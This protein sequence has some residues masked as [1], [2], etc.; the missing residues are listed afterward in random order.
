MARVI[1]RTQRP[2]SRAELRQLAG[3]RE[4]RGRPR[5]AAAGAVRI[6]EGAI[7]SFW[8]K[9][10]R[11]FTVCTLLIFGYASIDPWS[12]VLAKQLRERAAVA[13]VGSTTSAARFDSTLR[14]V[15]SSVEELSN[16]AKSGQLGAPLARLEEGL[17]QLRDLREEVLADFAET[18]EWLGEKG[19]PEQIR[20]RHQSAVDAFEDSYR[21]LERQ[22][23]KTL[24]ASR[25]A[26]R[27]RGRGPATKEIGILEKSLRDAEKSLDRLAPERPHTPI[28]P[29][30]L[31]HRTAELK[32]QAPR[33]T[34]AE[35]D[36]AA[37]AVDATTPGTKAAPATPDDVAPTVDAQFTPEII[38]LAASLD[39]DP[40]KIYEFVRNSIRF[41]PTAGSTQ[42]AAACLSTRECNATDTASLLIALL[43]AS[44]IP[45]RWAIG[46]VEVPIAKVTNWVGGFSDPQ[47]AL[48]FIASAGTPVAGLTSGGDLVAARMEHVWVEAFVDYLPSRGAATGGGA[49]WVPLDASFK[50][51]SF[52]GGID[53]DTVIPVDTEALV[54]Q[55]VA[56]G[57]QDPSGYA[58]T[59]LDRTV[60]QGTLDGIESDLSSFI[61]SNI[62]SP[63]VGDLVDF[64]QIVP[65]S[66]PVLPAS[67]PYRIVTRGSV[68][69]TLPASLRH[70][71]TFEVTSSSFGFFPDLSFSASLPE[72]AGKKITLSYAPATATD[73]QTLLAF[74]PEDTGD[75][76][77]QSDF[78][79][80]LPAHLVNVK[81]ELRVGGEVVAT[82]ASVTLG[83]TGSFRM[84]FNQPNVG[85]NI[86]D[87]NVTAGTYNAIVLNLGIVEDPASRLAA[88]QAVLDQ[89]QTGAGGSL[90]K[91]DLMGEFLYGAGLFYWTKLELARRVASHVNPVATARL[92]SE[93]I[94]TYD[95]A[96]SFLFGVPRTVE[97]GALLTDVDSDVQAVLA[98]DGDAAKAL[99][100][101]ASTGIVASRA[102]PAIWD[103]LINGAATGAGIS[104]ASFIDYAD[105]QGIPIFHI[106][107]DNVAAAL[108]LLQVSAAVKTDIQNAVN[109]GRIVTVPQQEV[110]LDGFAG[111]GYVIFDPATG[112][113][114]YIISSGLA[115]GGFQL[116]EL[117]P[118][119]NA[120]LGI[121]LVGIGVFATGGLAIAAAIAAIALIVYDF[122]ATMQAISRN[123]PNLNPDQLELLTAGLAFFAIVGGVLALIGIFAGSLLAF[124]AFAVAWILYSIIA[125]LL[126]QMI[127]G[128][129]N[130][131]NPLQA[132]AVARLPRPRSRQQTAPIRVADPPPRS[133]PEDLPLAA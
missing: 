71:L 57:S 105:Q 18:G 125:S 89:L 52:T 59:G 104:A 43:R 55:L 114:G 34:A 64:A 97:S 24:K 67:L 115:G 85:T 61:A 8:V 10:L 75:P 49:I 110:V 25:K 126:I 68:V 33:L 77:P 7:R 28:D 98:K 23:K 128:I 40:L 88:A 21:A 50:Q 101:T 39:N 26:A 79:S 12:L 127:A 47:A 19:L 42:G 131:T 16:Q 1:D 91:D 54:D 81:P 82:G 32:E 87:N 106:N 3:F 2:G 84:I 117:H 83:T 100:Y 41:V 11:P 113:G 116:P 44:D 66:L 22:L 129:G 63:T 29:L 93:G 38:D 30:K 118:L 107:A 48:N 76:I 124:V 36:A 73:E 108:P 6:P 122:I 72:L 111:V 17:D 20:Q 65:Q 86:V 15:K 132:P 9:R 58:I 51:L 130:A 13:T 27:A 96:V 4:E 120:L 78:P 103:E 119:L 112:A 74:L 14:A 94:F 70:Q 92:P 35:L 37:T 60:I 46:T 45:A 95:L 53:L 109:A 69:S 90:T 102:E 121:L 99:E 31:P 133:A 56:S 80:S 5:T 123:N 62:P